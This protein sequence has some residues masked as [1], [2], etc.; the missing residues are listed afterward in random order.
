VIVPTMSNSKL[1]LQVVVNSGAWN[2]LFLPLL[3]R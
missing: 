3:H 2:Y 1:K